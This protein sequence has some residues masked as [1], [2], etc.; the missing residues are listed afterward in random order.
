[1]RPEREFHHL[2]RTSTEIKIECNYKSHPARLCVKSV[3]RY[4]FAILFY[5]RPITAPYR[6][7]TFTLE[8]AMKAQRGV[9]A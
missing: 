6:K 1:M 5:N 4:R 8:Q 7:D 9:E 3:D 2:P